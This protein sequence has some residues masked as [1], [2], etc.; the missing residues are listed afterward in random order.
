MPLDNE[1]RNAPR[2]SC[3]TDEVTGCAV[4][5]KGAYPGSDCHRPAHRIGGISIVWQLHAD[6]DPGINLPLESSPVWEVA[7]A[8]REVALVAVR[9]NSNTGACYLLIYQ[10]CRRLGGLAA[11]AATRLAAA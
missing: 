1:L 2:S 4:D 11:F 3:T 7:R 8:H 5:P 10:A 6:Q 9:I